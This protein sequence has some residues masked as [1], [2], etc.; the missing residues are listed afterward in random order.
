MRGRFTATAQLPFQG[1]GLTRKTLD[2]AL[3]AAAAMA[4]VD[5]RR[6][7]AVR[8]I[9]ADH[10]ALTVA[11]DRERVFTP[12]TLLLASGKHEVR[13][14]ARASRPGALVGFKTYFALRPEAE[15]DLAGHVELI[16]F[17][18]GGYAGLQMVEGNVANLC[19]LAPAAV[20]AR[21]GGKFAGLLAH[22]QAASPHLAGRLAGAVDTLATP[23]SI[24]RIP[25]G[26]V[27]QPSPTDPDR[28]FRLG[29][30]AAVIPSFSGDGMAIALHSAARAAEFILAGCSAHDYHRRLR[31]D[32]AGQ[33]RR[34]MLIQMMF[35]TPFAG[36]LMAGAARLFPAILPLAASLT[37]VPAPVRLYN[38]DQASLSPSV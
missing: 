2:E 27:H 15:A 35:N 31:A 14:A 6:G 1:L 3:L 21:F 33:I 16:I 28:L 25:Y 20:L 7:H 37:R 23:L 12:R 10:G 17:P 36:P 5:V 19:L 4:G 24:A 9:S 11:V 29:D 34:G 18:G 13:G 38:A 32:V 22:L 8:N 30:Q 26:F